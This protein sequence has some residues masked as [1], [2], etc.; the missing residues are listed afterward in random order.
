MLYK[1]WTY[2]YCMYCML[3]IGHIYCMRP[4]PICTYNISI[5]WIMNIYMYPE[6]HVIKTAWNSQDNNVYILPKMRLAM[7]RAMLI[8]PSTMVA[9]SE[10]VLEAIAHSPSL[11][12]CLWTR[13]ACY[14]WSWPPSKESA[15][16]C[17]TSTHFATRSIVPLLAHWSGRDYTATIWICMLC[18][19]QS[20]I[21][22]SIVYVP[23]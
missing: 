12:H 6:I 18:I 3:C 23:I 17:P 16:P 4:I 9:A 7:N 10:T 21:M 22:C 11:L 5:A 1:L 19:V 15:S 13:L 2:V 20:V 14:M 8:I